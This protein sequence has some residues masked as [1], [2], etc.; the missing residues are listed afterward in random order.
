MWLLDENLDVNLLAFLRGQEIECDT[1]R[2]RGWQGLENGEL[3]K[4]AWDEGF[5]WLLTRDL[6]FATAAGDVFE[7]YPALAIVLISLPQKVSS[8]YVSD[9]ARLGARFNIPLFGAGHQVA[10]RVARPQVRFG[11][12]A[13]IFA[14]SASMRARFE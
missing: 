13:S 9:F 4:V 11:R 14:K 10:T 1:V 6:D 8:R 12:P 2:G 5:R 7:R 3:A